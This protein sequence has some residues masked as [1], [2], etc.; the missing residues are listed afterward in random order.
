MVAVQGGTLPGSYGLTE[1]EVQA[2]QIGRT[3]VTWDEWQTVRT[4]A[5]ANGYTDLAGVG[6]GSAGNHPVRNVSWYDVVKWAN[7]KSQR[8]GLTPVYS[9]NGTIY[10]IGLFVPTPNSAAN[11]YRLPGEA[12]WEWAARGGIVSTGYSYSGGNNLAEVGW[13]RGNSEGAIIDLSSTL[14]NSKAAT[15]TWP[16]AQKKPNELG[17][18]DMSG[19]ISEW[20]WDKGNPDNSQIGGYQR[21]LR[22]PSW[23]NDTI[24]ASVIHRTPYGDPTARIAVTGLRL[25][26]NAG[27]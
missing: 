19:N 9:V 23:Y 17:L 7:A 16:V 10:K 1:Q 18:F 15:G 13:Y 12:E 22:G 4:W 25:A 27:N 8:E 3:E 21:H 24:E 2:F 14:A 6:Q 20:C 26:R 5:L 11:G